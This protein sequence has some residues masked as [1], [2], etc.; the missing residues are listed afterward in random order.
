[1]A[2]GK[3]SKK[4]LFIFG[5][6]GI[7]L[8][9]VILL[10][11]FGGNN[12]RIF[13]VQTEKIEKR[14]ITQIVSAN[15]KIN[16][17]EQVIL[18]PEVTGEIVDLPVEEGDHVAKGQLLIRLKPDQYIARRNQAE[19]SLQSAQANLKVRKATLDQVE[20][21]YQRMKG[22]YE[23]GLASDS[24]LELS[25]A[26]FLQNE[27]MYEA[28]LAAVS[29]MH[30]SYNDAVV[31]LSKTT[32]YSPIEGTISELNVE[33]SERVLGSSF[34][35]GTH[36]MTVADLTQMEATVD[37]DENDVVLI[38]VGD[39]AKIEIDAFSD[40]K[41]LGKVTQIGNSA[42]TTGLGTQ[43]EVVNFEVKIKLLDVDPNIRPGMSCDSDIETETKLDVLAVPIQSVTARV[44]KKEDSAED[45]ESN[46]Q[47]K[48]TKAPKPVEIVFIKDNDVAKR[49]DVK[50]GISDDTY[51]EVTSGVE[52]GQEVISGPYKAISKDL[53]DGSKIMEQKKRSESETENN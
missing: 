49:L 41:F 11:V 2:N 39:T 53:E 38:S 47:K 23:K 28:Q 36:L 3:K 6:L 15:G 32:I 42:Q 43:D 52:E 21:E 8:I 26:S 7:L 22:L 29:Q 50:T 34:S 37:V 33:M 24:E 45:E 19:A 48:I 14:D 30:E 16:P 44:E 4:K 51:I 18:R 5:G 20:A 35:Q 12:E 17:I 25:K 27:G 9:V 1:M 46:N 10:A 31:E 40:R 13:S